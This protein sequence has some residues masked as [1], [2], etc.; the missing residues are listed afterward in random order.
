V[1]RSASSHAALA[2]LADVH[3]ARLRRID[4]DLAHDHG[5]GALLDGLDG[6]GELDLVVNAT[7]LLHDRMVAPEKSIEQVSRDAL[8]AVFAINAFAPVLLART[9]MPRLAG[10]RP[11]V[12][13]SL[14]ARVGSI[15]DN[16]AGGWYAYRASKAAQNQLM[17]TFAIEWRR[18][19]PLGTCLLLHPGTVD[20]ALSAPFQSRV[21]AHRLF[22]PASAAGKLLRVIASSSPADTGRFVAWDGTDIPW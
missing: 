5:F 18:R 9:L 6:T 11:A 10:R 19:N 20:T 22:D 21:P 13:A 15:G 17:R 8:E 14:S 2:A 7:G 4:A 12:F 1:S 3:G 16:R